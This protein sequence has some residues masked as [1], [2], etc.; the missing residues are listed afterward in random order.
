M[1]RDPEVTATDSHKSDL[2]FIIREHLLDCRFLD[3][4]RGH[5]F[6]RYGGDLK[7]KSYALC[8]L[9]LLIAGTKLGPCEV[10]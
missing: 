3:P 5:R 1:A 10:Q 2:S 9:T 4:S 7:R 8:A 6:D